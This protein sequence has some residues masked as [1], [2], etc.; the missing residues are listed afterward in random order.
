MADISID[1]CD[2]LLPKAVA[3]RFSNVRCRGGRARQ[4]LGD[5]VLSGLSGVR[6]LTTD[7]VVQN[8]PQRVDV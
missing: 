6:R 5:N 2:R 4:D 3:V 1:S 7:D 8:R